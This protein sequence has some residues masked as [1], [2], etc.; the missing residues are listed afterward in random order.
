[1]LFV[2]IMMTHSYNTKNSINRTKVFKLHRNVTTKSSK[3]MI[4]S[5]EVFGKQR[6]VGL[7]NN[8]HGGRLESSGLRRAIVEQTAHPR[9]ICLTN[10][11][12]QKHSYFR[13]LL[14]CHRL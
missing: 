5:L 7:L 13:I 3:G 11:L 1:M 14:K 9:H 6:G 8:K 10:F 2:I 4:R 12:G